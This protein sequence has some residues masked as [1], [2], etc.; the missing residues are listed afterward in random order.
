ME[1]KQ[2]NLTVKERMQRIR[3]LSSN[4]KSSIYYLTEVCNIRCKGCWYYANDMDKISN[5]MKSLDQL[6]QFVKQEAERG[7]T[8]PWIIGGE[9]TLFPKRLA[10][11]V[12]H[13]PYVI[14]ATNG[15]LPLPK[16]GFENVHIFVSV[17]GSL[18]INDYFRARRIDGT[19]FTGLLEGALERYKNDPRAVYV[20]AT[21]E[22][23][24]DELEET[25]QRIRDAGNTCVLSYYRHYRKLG[26]E[27][28]Y[29]YQPCEGPGHPERQQMETERLLETALSLREKYP[30]T[31]ISHPYYIRSLITGKSEWGEFGY[32]ECP[33]IT[34]DHK[35]NRDR[36]KNGNPCL[37]E[38]RSY[39]QDMETL[40]MCCTSGDCV[41]CRDSQAVINWL[42][43]NPKKFA[44]AEGSFETW[45]ELAESY[46]RSF[47]WSKFN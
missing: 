46:W 28:K 23:A 43:A 33:T 17:F 42:L 14:V 40:N 16:D 6:E 10:V 8:T 12:K 36:I 2:P 3:Q 22:S 1:H 11:F 4:I 41:A 19:R 25:I 37:P 35:K 47:V 24:V 45:V 21:S 18:K 5:D 34:F 31:I 30:E 13:M 39:S 44:K 9:P 7:I 38:F 27:K 29:D 26:C 32:A 15:L 20:L